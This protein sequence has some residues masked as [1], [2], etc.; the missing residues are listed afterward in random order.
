MTDAPLSP[1]FLRVLS[2]SEAS[3]GLGGPRDEASSWYGPVTRP[4]AST[5]CCKS[6]TVCAAFN[7]A[8]YFWPLSNLCK[9]CDL[10]AI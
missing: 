1:A 10:S 6:R 5:T 9:W 2:K 3:I 4:P 8:T 7:F